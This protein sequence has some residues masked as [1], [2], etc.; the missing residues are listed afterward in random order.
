MELC[1]LNAQYF[2]EFCHQASNILCGAL[3]SA[4]SQQNGMASLKA[5]AVQVP[6]DKMKFTAAIFPRN[7]SIGT[8]HFFIDSLRVRRYSFDISSWKI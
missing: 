7:G 6:H 3:F 4:P 5:G 1:S 8:V 2:V